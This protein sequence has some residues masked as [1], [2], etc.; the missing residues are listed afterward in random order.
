MSLVRAVIFL[1]AIGVQ[2]THAKASSQ[3]SWS[4]VTRDG[5]QSTYRFESGEAMV[6]FWTSECAQYLRIRADLFAISNRLSA[7]SLEERN[8]V[9]AW[10]CGR[11]QQSPK[12]MS[13]IYPNAVPF[14]V[15]SDYLHQTL[16]LSRLHGPI[17]SIWI[18]SFLKEAILAKPDLR[19]LFSKSLGHIEHAHARTQNLA[20]EAPLGIRSPD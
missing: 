7:L 11:Q 18:R 3:W 6:D 19:A 12:V 1:N 5:D 16:A 10:I 13:A 14:K 9:S 4:T 2:T 20:E 17:G 8:E 15:P